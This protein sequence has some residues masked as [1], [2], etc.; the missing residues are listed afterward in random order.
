[1]A[2]PF[3][4]VITSPTGGVLAVTGATTGAF[5]TA[6]PFPV[7]L[8]DANGNFLNLGATGNAGIMVSRLNTDVLSS[9][10]AETVLF[11]ATIPAGLM[12]VN[13]IVILNL[14][15]RTGTTTGST[16]FRVRI[17]ASGSG[18]TGTVLAQPSLATANLGLGGYVTIAN[19][20]SLSAQ[21]GGPMLHNNNAVDST[22]N[23]TA[24]VNT[25]NAWDIVVTAQM[26]NADANGA[27]LQSASVIVYP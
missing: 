3:P 1:M 2:N 9:L 15:A 5:S 22:L 7:T 6:A 13:G 25:A 20:N 18:L 23:A 14:L 16:T 12:T 24:T 4:V 10:Q 11:T 8:T 27:N 26:A 17:A 21:V 19:R